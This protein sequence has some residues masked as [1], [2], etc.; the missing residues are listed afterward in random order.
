MGL[1]FDHEDPIATVPLEAGR[2]IPL[3]AQDLD[4]LVPDLGQVG[5]VAGADDGR[6]DACMQAAYMNMRTLLYC[7]CMHGRCR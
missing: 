7:L 5:L 2:V 4:P 1:V 3:A 6:V